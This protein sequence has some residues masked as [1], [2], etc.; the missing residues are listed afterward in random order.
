MKKLLGF[1]FAALCIAALVSCAYLKKTVENTPSNE[2]YEEATG[3]DVSLEETE[4]E[5]NADMAE[6]TVTPSEDAKPDEEP[7]TTSKPEPTEAPTVVPT[8]TPTATKGPAATTSPSAKPTESPSATSTPKP[9]VAPTPV[10]TTAP[11]PVPTPTPIPV[12]AECNKAPDGKHYYLAT[13]KKA[14]CYNEGLDFEICAYCGGTR[15]EVPIPK[16]EHDWYEWYYTVPECDRNGWLIHNCKNCNDGWGESVP[17][18]GH[19]YVNTVTSVA[20]CIQ[21]QII[22]PIC[23]V[24]GWEDRYIV[25]E[26][27]YNN[28][29]GTWIHKSEEVVNEDTWE[30]ETHYYEVC[31]ACNSR[32]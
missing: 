15:N 20:S 27:D 6:P 14:D 22:T 10:P 19:S 12:V 18:P 4:K 2:V 28:H 1:I 29:V 30:Y 11:T 9:T 5:E 21:S 32:R 23:S 26:K 24:C 13:N 7:S 8:S 25:G 3:G 31:A 16:T 17:A